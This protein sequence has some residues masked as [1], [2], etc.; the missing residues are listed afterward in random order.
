[1]GRHNDRVSRKC[2]H[3][4]GMQ[5]HG[6]NPA[7]GSLRVEDRGEKFPGFV[8]PDLPFGFVSPHLLVE[9]VEKLLAGSGSGK[10]SA[11]VQSSTE[12]AKV[13]QPFRSAVEWHAHAIQ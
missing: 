10:S 8:F 5:V 12:A 6:A 4:H 7:A 13:E 2:S 1:A 9:S 11:V 3:F